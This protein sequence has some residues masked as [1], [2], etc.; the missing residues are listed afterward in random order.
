[1]GCRSQAGRAARRPGQAACAAAAAA[2]Q[3]SVADQETRDLPVAQR[4]RP[5]TWRAAGS[6]GRPRSR[7]SGWT[8]PG[9]PCRLVSW[10]R[11]RPSSSRYVL[12]G[13]PALLVPALL[14][15]TGPTLPP[16]RG[17]GHPERSSS[18]PELIRSGVKSGPSTCSART[19]WS[20]RGQFSPPGSRAALLRSGDWP[21][22]FTGQTRRPVTVTLFAI[23]AATGGSC[24]AQSRRPPP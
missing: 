19:G 9:G 17:S 14:V 2:C 20:S 8:A 12:A 13:A 11:S 15:L 18:G 3:P 16:P 6:A 7:S 5:P 1:M 23:T 24:C 21:E 22:T 10:P 4:R